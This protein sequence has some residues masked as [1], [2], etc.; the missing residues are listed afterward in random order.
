[1]LPTAAPASSG[2]VVGEAGQQ[3]ANRPRLDA[4]SGTGDHEYRYQL[5]MDHAALREV[6]EV[7]RQAYSCGVPEADYMY[8]S[9]RLV[10]NCEENLAIVVAELTDGEVA[11][12]PNGAAAAQSTRVPTPAVWA[13]LHAALESAGWPR[14]LI[15][16]RTQAEQAR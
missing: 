6:L 13:R 11:I 5:T 7:L 12:V 9:L 8:C 10:T 2:D 15:Y 4:E 16:P 14:T 1:V 3:R